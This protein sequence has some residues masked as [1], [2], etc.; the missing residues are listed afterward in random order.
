MRY[1]VLTSRTFHNRI[2]RYLGVL[3]WAALVATLGLPSVAQAQVTDYPVVF[4]DNNSNDFMVTAP[5]DP[6][7]T[8]HYWVLDVQPPSGAKMQ[9]LTNDASPTAGT[10][11]SEFTVEADAGLGTWTFQLYSGMGTPG[12]DEG[13]DVDMVSE[14]AKTDVGLKV[15]YFHGAPSMPDNFNYAV[16]GG[17]NYLFSWDD[18]L[19]DVKGPNKGI[20]GYRLRWTAGD[21]TL[22]ATKWTPNAAG[23]T[24]S[25]TGFHRLSSTQGKALKDGSTYT[26][27]LFADGTS[28]KTA[29]KVPSSPAAIIMVPVGMVPTPTLPEFAA[30]F[31]AMLLLGSGAYLIR[32]RQSSGL[33]SA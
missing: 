29:N 31:L 12:A 20:T 10:D 15:S 25:T 18:E 30:L 3:V 22:V 21:P 7:T 28:P 19:E 26:F 17:D 4:Y 16:S 32:R 13:N 5:N 8:G 23:Q 24:V 14:I 1:T 27:Q 11:M 33:I 6:P 9:F 2:I